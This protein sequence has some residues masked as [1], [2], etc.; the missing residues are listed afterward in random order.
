[1]VGQNLGANQVGR[2]HDAAWRAVKLG[3]WLTGAWGLLMILTPDSVVE[4]MSPGPASTGYA[5]DYLKIAG[6]VIMF[7]TVEIVLE[8]AFAGA[9][10]TVPA[11]MLGLPFTLLRV[12]AAIAARTL[13][14]GVNGIFWSLAL[15]S[16]VR[17]LLFAFWF[18]RGKWIHAKA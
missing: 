5:A 1:M 10:D 18:A 2:A 8:G 13:G 7:T 14:L 6:C 9:G 4:L 15:T 17:G 3:V 12:P 16:V 11:M